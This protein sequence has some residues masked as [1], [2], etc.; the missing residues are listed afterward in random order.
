MDY[1]SK[2]EKIWSAINKY[3]LACGGDPTK[4][5][6]SSEK[7]SS[8]IEIDSLLSVLDEESGR[9]LK[10]IRYQVFISG[11]PMIEF[12]S[13]VSA[14]DYAARHV[15]QSSDR[16][17]ESTKSLKEG[18]KIYYCYGTKEVEITPVFMGLG[19]FK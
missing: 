18:N 17:E 7:I 6:L 1:K 4:N 2:K 15:Y 14:I 5:T 19:Y 12:D 13:I 3:T 8:I 10:S 9:G 16:W 11:E